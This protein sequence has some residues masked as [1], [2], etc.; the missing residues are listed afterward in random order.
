M[1]EEVTE[2]QENGRS[3][4]SVVVGGVGCVCCLFGRFFNFISFQNFFWLV[5]YMGEE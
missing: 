2:R 3:K 1:N 4:C 5:H